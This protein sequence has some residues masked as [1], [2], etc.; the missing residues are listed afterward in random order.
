MK[1]VSII[2]PSTHW[3]KLSK[4]FTN[5]EDT[6]S[7][8]DSFEVLVK[9][10]DDNPEMIAYLEAEKRKRPFSIRYVATP[11][12][13]GRWDIHL[14]YNEAWEIS[15]PETYFVIGI[16]D[17]TTFATKNWDDIL[18]RYVGYFPDD[19]FH[20]RI[21]QRRHLNFKSVVECMTCGESYGFY[22]KRWLSLT[23]GPAVGEA[24]VDTGQSC[25][26]YFLRTQCGCSRDVVVDDIKVANEEIA[27]SATHGLSKK[28]WHEKLLRIYDVYAQSLTRDK[29]ENFYRLAR[30]LNAYI[31][32][33]ENNLPHFEIED[34]RENK[35][36]LVKISS[37]SN[38][39]KS[40]PYE[41]DFAAW[42]SVLFDIE[43]VFDTLLSWDRWPPLIANQIIAR[44]QLAQLWL[45]TAPE[46]VKNAYLGDLGK[47]HKKLLNI[48]IRNKPLT[49]VRQFYM[50]N[51]IKY[52]A[53]GYSELEESA[54]VD[55]LVGRVLNGLDDKTSVQ[56]LLAALLYCRDA[57]LLYQGF[58]LNPIPKWLLDDLGSV[59]RKARVE[60][61]KDVL[62]KFMP[63]SVLRAVKSRLMKTKNLIEEI[64]E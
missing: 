24:G 46:Q 18:R 58:D 56:D 5:L 37:Q 30:N 8:M 44:R 31:W 6:A 55:D 15:S 7:D 38:P 21:S 17:E 64:W 4:L 19:V 54:F 49:T 13:R 12:R 35:E 11:R 2:L 29:I 23:E 53:N 40:F 28:E 41:V 50:N 27:A 16:N 10:D 45:N 51:L 1:L 26:N 25:V 32:A 52:I 62:V 33:T 34:D 60:R 48:S 61:T 39:L 63:H 3:Q 42:V 20:L 59:A 22:T 36:I 9:V 47:A 57:E 43:P 14:G